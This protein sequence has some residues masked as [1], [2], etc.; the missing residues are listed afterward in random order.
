M[1]LKNKI[2]SFSHIFEKEDNVL[3]QNEIQANKLVCSTMAIGCVFLLLAYFA[4]QV[5]FYSNTQ[6]NLSA[7][8][9]QSTLELLIP[10]VLCHFFKAQKSWIKYISFITII[11]VLARI[12]T[13]ISYSVVLIMAIPVVLACRYFNKKFIVFV[14]ILTALLFGL[15]T[16]ANAYWNF[17]RLD[18]NYYSLPQGTTLIIESTIEDA[19]RKIGIDVNLRTYYAMIYNYLPKLFIFIIISII[20]YRI[21]ENGKQMVLAQKSITEKNSRIENELNLAK[22]IQAHMLPSIFPA[23]PEDKEFDLYAFMEPAKEVGGDFYDFYKLD[24]SHLA[25]IIA[26][27]SGKGIPA[28]LFM[29]ISKTILKNEMHMGYSAEEA[30]GRVNHMLCEG[31]QDG[32]FVTAWI[33]VFNTE[34]GELTYVSAGHNPP[35]IKQNDSYRYLKTRPGFI[36]AGMDGIKYHS[37]TITLSPGDKLFLYTDGIVEAIDR[38]ETMYGE[39]KLLAYLNAHINDSCLDTIQGV[40]EDVRTFASGAEQFDDITMLMLEFKHPKEVLHMK[41]KVF[42]V[43]SDSL[44]T[45]L[46]YIEK[47]LLESNCPNKII[48]QILVCSEEIYVNIAKYAYTNKK[49]IVTISTLIDAE[50]AIIQFSDSGVLFNPLEMKDPDI[51][52]SVEERNVGGLGIYIVKKMMDHV[53]Y[54]YQ[55]GKNVLT[56]EKSYNNDRTTK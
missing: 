41:E 55:N 46:E 20:C 8:I 16:F 19:I 11:G 52:L 34:N 3:W 47:E 33:G 37:Q 40:R 38:K 48:Q 30:V 10:P 4:I 13:Y 26:D 35:L 49:G 2:K 50:K 28:A 54:V 6:V 23:F 18:V 27:V 42:H 29:V 56:I 5:G 44:D 43:E 53:N 14:S 17:G 31:N 36:L 51:S 39:N 7:L 21:A 32:M 15:S 25:L 1:E 24:E 9:F 12:N 22:N 45:I